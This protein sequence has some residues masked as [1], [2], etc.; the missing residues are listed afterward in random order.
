MLTSLIMAKMSLSVVFIKKLY[1]AIYNSYSKTLLTTP[2][3]TEK[4]VNRSIAIFIR[5][6]YLRRNKFEQVLHES[7]S[8]EN[9]S[10]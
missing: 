3:L 7:M 8:R 5:T 1:L 2:Y 6:T 4:L 9:V 10:Y